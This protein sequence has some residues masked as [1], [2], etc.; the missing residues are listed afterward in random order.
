MSLA[1]PDDRTAFVFRNM[2]GIKFEARAIMV[3]GNEPYFVRIIRYRKHCAFFAD[4][5]DDIRR[6]SLIQK[7]GRE[8]PG[9][10]PTG[11]AIA[12]LIDAVD[13]EDR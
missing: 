13:V 2:R 6:G 12:E 5:L 7:R 10:S 11:V 1:N 3:N 9:S 4:L 8:F